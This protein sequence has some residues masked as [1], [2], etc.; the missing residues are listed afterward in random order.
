MS[1]TK[2]NRKCS[3][4]LSQESIPDNDFYSL[5]TKFDEKY[6]IQ[7]IALIVSE[8]YVESF[9]ADKRL[10]T[11]HVMQ[12]DNEI[13]K[14]EILCT[15]PED[16][17]RLHRLFKSVG[18]IIYTNNAYIRAYDN[19]IVLHND[20]DLMLLAMHPTLTQLKRFVKDF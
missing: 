15:C 17:L 12:R 9:E 19:V 4:D 18:S 2:N 5:N 1:G 7:F 8:L 10:W 3:Q 16:E 20:P 6:F 14:V 11:F 13:Q